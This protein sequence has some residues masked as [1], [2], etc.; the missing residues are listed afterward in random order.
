MSAGFSPP[1]AFQTNPDRLRSLLIEL[2]VALPCFLHLVLG[3]PVVVVMRLFSW[4]SRR[5]GGLSVLFLLSLSCWAVYDELRSNKRLIV[6]IND[7]V[8]SGTSSHGDRS[9]Q[10]GRW[11]VVFAYYCLFIHV[12]VFVFPLRACWSIWSVT[13]K[14][15][16]DALSKAM[17][18]YKKASIRR[19]VSTTS[20]CSLDTM[21]SGTLTAE[22]N[23][24]SEAVSEASDSEPDLFPDGANTSD[25]M[26][27]H[28]I[29][30]PNYKEEVDTLRETL[31]VLASHSEASRSYD[32]SGT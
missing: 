10:S 31:E 29:I 15:K 5:A 1:G 21:S 8:V 14:L 6:P 2:C 26:V 12:L 20:I 9:G 27:V 23:C 24:F 32:V 7:G 19:R 25:A 4:C 28:A 11:V 30:L 17:Q 16:K 18:T 3:N 22:S 13:Q